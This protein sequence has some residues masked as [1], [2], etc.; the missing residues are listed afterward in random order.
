[1]ILQMGGRLLYRIEFNSKYNKD[2]WTI[3]LRSR[4]K[5]SM[6]GLLLGNNQG[7]QVLGKLTSQNT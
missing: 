6:D 4:V 7:R 3:E 2:T 1:M 5:G